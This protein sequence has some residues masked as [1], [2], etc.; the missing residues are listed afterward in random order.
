MIT[1]TI[2]DLFESI[3]S[4]NNGDIKET[5]QDLTDLRDDIQASPYLYIARLEN[6]IRAKVEENHKCPKCFGDMQVTYD[7]CEA[8][9]YQ[10]TPVSEPMHILMCKD[11]G[12]VPL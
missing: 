5:L 3:Q 4:T 10:G 2:L 12:Y 9:E 7:G 11:C 1:I 8:S 6:F